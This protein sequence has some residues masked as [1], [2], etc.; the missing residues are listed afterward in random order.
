MDLTCCNCTTQKTDFCPKK[1]NIFFYMQDVSS[2]FKN[3]NTSSYLSTFVK[4]ELGFKQYYLLCS[5]VHIAIPYGTGVMLHSAQLC[6]N[7][8]ADSTG[9]SS[10]GDRSGNVKK[11]IVILV[12]NYSDVIKKKKKHWL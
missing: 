7:D 9:E 4:V 11:L 10:S 2:Y 12:L 6:F 8:A 3:R 5:N 1:D